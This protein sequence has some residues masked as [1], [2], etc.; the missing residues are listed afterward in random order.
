[1]Q[2]STANIR[3]LP[4]TIS[5]SLAALLLFVSATVEAA[6][7]SS[8]YRLEHIEN[9]RQNLQQYEWARAIVRGWENSVRY[10]MGQ[11]RE[12][13][14]QLIPELTPGTHYGQTCPACVDR[15][16]KR[17]ERNFRWDVTDPDRLTC[18]DC[19]TVFPSDAHPETGVLEC[20]RMGQTFTYYQMPEERAFGPDATVEQR[21]E[22]AILGVSNRP[23]NISMSSTIRYY[24][25]SWAWSQVLTLAKLYALTD[26][27]AYAERVF[28][29]LDRFARVFPRYLYH[30]YYGSFAD[31]PPAEVAAS[32]GDPATPSGGRFP[33]DVIRH[34]YGASMGQDKQGEYST[35]DNGFWG[36]GRINC[37]GMGSDAAPMFN[38]TIAYDLV[39]DATY[40]D[41]Q[42]VA[43]E[44][45]HARI[46]NDLI[47][48]GCTDM[49]YWSDLS[50]KGVATR[51][52]SVAVGIL[53][54]Q[55]ERVRRGIDGFYDILALRYHFDGFYTESPA[56]ARHNYLSMKDLPDLLQGYSDP[57]GYQPPDGAR[58]DDFRPFEDGHFNLALV[59][60]IRMLAPG[61]MKP[62]IGDTNA[63][64]PLSPLY[65]EILAA[66]V[67]GPY[68]ALLEQLSE[69]PLSEYGTEYSLWY[70]PP[71]LATQN[72]MQL[73]LHSEWF[74][75]WHVGVL[76]GGDE[77]NNTALYLVGD[78]LNWTIRSGHRHADVLHMSYYAFG[79]ELVT[80]RGYFS[81][82]NHRTPDGR[83]GQSWT[84]GTLSHNLVV[85]DETNQ[86][87][88][89]RGSNLE[90][91]GSVPGVEMLQAS[92][93]GVYDQCS[94]YRRTCAHVEM[95]QGG[96]YIVD[97]FR[98]EGGQVHQYIFHSA[99]SLVDITPSQPAPQPTEL[100]EAWSRW[101][102]NP[103][104]IVPEIPHTFGW[105]QDDIRVD[106]MMLNSTDTLQHIIITDAPGWRIHSQTTRDIDPIQQILAENRADDG[107]ELASR[108][109]AVIVPYTSDVSPVLSAR[110]LESDPDTGA[111]AVEVRFA[112]R[113]DY[114][115]STKDGELRQYGPIEVAGQ[116]G[117][118]SVDNAGHVTRAYLLAGTYLQ[119][120]ETVLELPQAIT[121]LRLA[122]VAG[123]T[124]T[125]AEPLPAELAETARFV[126][127]D[128]PQPLVEGQSRPRTGFEIES[129][130]TDSITVRDYPV[131][132]CDEITILHSAWV[133]VEP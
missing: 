37:H 97:L 14:E 19:G 38:F 84:A 79:Q 104:Q 99:G 43:D 114:I 1:L 131:P 89:P 31:W 72:D 5:L 69:R 2:T 85:V 54:E 64:T 103:R 75:G 7:S 9:A 20:P 71:N 121:T 86:A 27:V 94:E 4:G 17:G 130:S 101:V 83:L 124:F 12:F 98:A 60:M 110:L 81:G 15:V 45:T 53:L 62:T 26:E 74:P 21:R 76:R 80:D 120:D 66:R 52:L 10:A 106:L 117:F 58:I 95:P 78:E 57:P 6:A 126:L 91:F 23:A 67:G 34:P 39:K 132:E 115:I 125:L 50:N 51:P 33:P 122:S 118:V 92:G 77:D 123:R 87:G 59:A 48:A 105:R 63:D 36:A 22:H 70:R 73:P 133:K 24:K 90:L 107:A 56:Y 25:V 127:T 113:T 128:G 116:F 55:P 3:V 49:D 96:H 82:S 108:Y 41:G 119:C 30:S 28:W 35:L 8:L 65:A 11:D 88:A 100:S 61:N 29:I 109:A 40:E 47:D 44:Q 16:S 68:V 42:S 93:F 46:R 32:M 102:D 111:M 13:F 18:R 112:N 129:I